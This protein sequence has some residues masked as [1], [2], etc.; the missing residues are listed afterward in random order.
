[1][2]EQKL[3]N[4]CLLKNTKDK[5]EA[6]I[7]K[8]IFKKFGISGKSFLI[9]D[10]R[11]CQFIS[12]Y[13]TLTEVIN[14]GI[15]SI[16]SLY[17]Q[18]KPYKSFSAIYIVS[19]DKKS[20]D[21]V[22]KD[23]KSDKGRLYKFCHLFILDEIKDD[24]LDIMAKNNFIKRI[25][26]L[27]Q[28]L[29]QYTPIDK[30]I[31]T[32]GNDENFNSI[33]NL[34]E[35]N[36]EMNKINISRLV[37]VCQSLDNYPNVVY[38]SFDN[39]CKLVA[40]KVNSEL[41]KYFSKKSVK[42]SGFLLITSRFIDLAAPVQFELIYQHLLLDSYKKKNEKFYNK[43]FLKT[44]NKT[45][46]KVLDYKDELYNKY[47]SMYIYEILQNINDDLAE[48]KKSDVGALSALK[49]EKNNID[50]NNA[51]KNM[52]KYQYYVNL[53]SE[54]INLC[55]EIDKILKRRNIMDLL[56]VQKTIISKMNNKGKKCSEND[57]ISLIKNNKDKFEKIDFMRL[58]CLIKYNYPEIEMD[59]IFS[60]LE[61]NNIIF[62]TAEKKIINF[63]NKGKSLINLD[64]LEELEKSII[65]YREK[66]NYKTNEENEN[67]NDKRY[68]YVKECKLTTICDMCSKNN[69]PKDIFTYVEKPE[70][71]KTQNRFGLKNDMFKNSE[72]DKNKQNLILFNIGGLSNYEI[73]SLERGSYINQYDV[74]L[75]L[76]ANKI[77]NYKEYFDELTHYFNGNNEIIK[78][79][80]VMPKEIKETK[81]N[82]KKKKEA[83]KN[84]SAEQKINVREINEKD[85][86]GKYSKEKLKKKKRND[87]SIT[88]DYK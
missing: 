69:L 14:F 31:F 23:F 20:I 15:F 4:N 43:I 13:L 9:V 73:A 11:G 18:R 61:S 58:L 41:K 71:I 83:E 10:N 33:Y 63:L 79:N 5:I 81:N 88:D 84:D 53:Y 52:S 26:T 77:Y 38:F 87:D 72:E 12:N 19:G 40:E 67:K 76:G 48:F 35:D 60:V 47:K 59:E 42:K 46:E 37:S 78:V 62:S 16:E 70:N 25:K 39:K 1:M 8:E 85:S 22:I 3:P 21:L 29:I 80:E 17:L 32:F 54:H 24:L 74:N 57:I 82:T 66:N 51:V 34:Y 64:S 28:I 2:L 50:L 56:D 30:N 7:F 55:T 68:N 49:N 27:K 86:D 75:I 36:E 44:K 6:Q 45:L 65:S